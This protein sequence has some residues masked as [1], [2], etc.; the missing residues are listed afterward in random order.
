MTAIFRKR[1]RPIELAAR[2]SDLARLRSLSYGGQVALPTLLNQF[3]NSTS[4]STWLRDLAAPSARVWL[5]TSRPL[6]SE[7]AGKAGCPE[8]PRPVCIGS[9]TR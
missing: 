8:H 4:S 1:R 3:S 5:E 6:K 2:G 9:S 7:G